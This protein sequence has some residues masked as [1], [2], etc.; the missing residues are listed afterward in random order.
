MLNIVRSDPAF[1]S[2]VRT[3]LLVLPVFGA[4]ASSDIVEL[5]HFSHKGV[6]PEGW[7]PKRPDADRPYFN[8]TTT[9]SADASVLEERIG[10]WGLFVSL[11]LLRFGRS[12]AFTLP[13][14]SGTLRE[15]SVRYPVKAPFLV[16]IPLQFDPGSGR[17]GTYYF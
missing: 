4:A 1:E 5:A 2:R 9:I 11:C 6:G 12:A 13:T 10:K 14:D 8:W 7:H 15:Y 17:C 16:E 3:E